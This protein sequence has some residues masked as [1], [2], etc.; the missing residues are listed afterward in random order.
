V[1]GATNPP[2]KNIPVA[3]TNH[4]DRQQKV[5]R[6]KVFGMLTSRAVGLYFVY[7]KVR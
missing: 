7:D 3:I 4:H 2:V 1:R 5:H 6:Q